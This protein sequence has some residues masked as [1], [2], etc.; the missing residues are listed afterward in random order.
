M[1]LFIIAISVICYSLASLLLVKRLRQQ[2]SK[3]HTRPA[4]SSLL[5]AAIASLVHAWVLSSG[6]VTGG[7]ISP[8]GLDVSIFTILSLI[9]WLVATLLIL[10]SM[11]QPV[12]CLGIIIFPFAAVML[13]VRET[14]SQHIYLSANLP[15]GLEAHI[16][17]SILA[18]SALSIAAIQGIFL[19]IQD[20]RLHNHH[21][22]GLIGALPPLETMENLLFKMIAVGFVL[23]T[24]ALLLGIP[25][26]ENILQQHLAHKTI[27]SSI[28]WVVF[29]ILLWG[30]WQFGWR[31]RIALRWIFTGF[32][33]LMLAYFGSQI[34]LQLIIQP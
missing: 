25:Y 21:P 12:D 11:R 16:I 6:H 3:E 32:I 9:S 17:L 8:L 22:K 7:I 19:Y 27:L 15:A 5:L 29:A 1:H 24:A 31:G 14:T 30:R 10:A 20:M 34:V 33:L 26:I 4:N 2:P 18:Y 28:A 13:V 23:L